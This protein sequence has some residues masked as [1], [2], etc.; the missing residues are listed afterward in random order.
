MVDYNN[1][2]QNKF[3]TKYHQLLF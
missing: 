2:R 1:M 3:Y